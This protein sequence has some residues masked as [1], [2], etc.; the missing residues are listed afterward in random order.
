MKVDELWKEQQAK[1]ENKRQ[2]IE[3]DLGPALSRFA[4]RE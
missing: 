2:E 1:R 3:S 4:R